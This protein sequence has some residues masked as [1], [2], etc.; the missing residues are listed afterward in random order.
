LNYYRDL[1]TDDSEIYL[2]KALAYIGEKGI[3]SPLLILEIIQNKPTIKFKV[4]KKYL[5]DRLKN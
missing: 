2:E 5:L 3:L 4:M 1:D